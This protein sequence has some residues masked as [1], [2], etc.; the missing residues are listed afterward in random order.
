MPPGRFSALDFVAPP[1]PSSVCQWIDTARRPRAV[2]LVATLLISL[3]IAGC[4]SPTAAPG[5]TNATPTSRSLTVADLRNNS[6]TALSPAEATLPVSLT[7]PE[8]DL[9]VSIVPMGWIVVE[10]EGERVSEWDLPEGAAGWH[11][12]S[13]L[14]GTGGNVVISGRQAGEGAVFA[15]LALGEVVAGQEIRLL[16]AEGRLFVYEVSEVSKPIPIAGATAAEKEQA[17]AY[18]DKTD[19][20]ILT[21]VSGWPEYTT[22]HR[23]FVVAEFVGTEE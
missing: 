14:A 9:D 20:A 17:A 16:D 21:L 15:P 13:E 1:S 22:T 3:F 11:L 5:A 12:N 2:I 8:I 18:L 4:T 6:T 23:V 19:R 7:I 10:K